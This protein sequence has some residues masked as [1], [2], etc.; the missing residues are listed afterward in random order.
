MPK[1]RPED[2]QVAPPAPRRRKGE[3]KTTRD[4][5][6][7]DDRSA[8]ATPPGAGLPEFGGSVPPPPRIESEWQPTSDEI[9]RRAY[10]IYETRGHQHGRDLDDWLQAEDELRKK[11][12]RNERSGTS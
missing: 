9:G 5:S 1:D 11:P 4:P 6:R 2:P 10:E 3:T 12:E 8:S 7:V